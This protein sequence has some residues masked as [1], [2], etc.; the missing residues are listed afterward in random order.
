MPAGKATIR[1][2]FVYDSGG[3]GKGGRGTLFVNGQKAAEGRIGNTVALVFSASEGADV[4]QD[5][6]TPATEDDK[7]RDSTLSRSSCSWRSTDRHSSLVIR[8]RPTSR[9]NA[10][11]TS[12][13]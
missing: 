9:S 2:E 8:P 13:R 1:Y 3:S 5:D 12:S 11:G 7:E 6:A 4:G 10:L